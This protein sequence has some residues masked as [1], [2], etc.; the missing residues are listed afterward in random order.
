[1]A[2]VRVEVPEPA[3][4]MTVT[5]NGRPLDASEYQTSVAID[6]R[7]ATIEA[8]APGRVP[9][10]ATSDVPP[11][12]QARFIV[13]FP[14]GAVVDVSD[15][16]SVVSVRDAGNGPHVVGASR[17]VNG[18]RVAGIVTLSV[19]AALGVAG[20]V[21]G[22]NARSID[23]RLASECPGGACSPTISGEQRSLIDEGRT[24]VTLT[25][26]SFIAG[27]A[28]AAFGVVAL[29]VSLSDGGESFAPGLARVS[30]FV[31]PSRGAA[32]LGLTGR[33]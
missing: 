25:N 24:M 32:G 13:R 6:G 33:F 21:T 19:G 30:P 3:P 27:G 2:F 23:D 15:S 22:L 28:L 1:M 10:R 31:D 5:L 8:V 12:Q 26:A 18:W 7:N 4:N 16:V 17:G 14:Q 29:I 20:V 9:Y 11:G